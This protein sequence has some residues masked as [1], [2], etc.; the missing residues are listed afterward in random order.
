VKNGLIVDDFG[1]KFWYKDDMLHREDGPAM[2]RRRGI[3]YWYINGKLHREDGP[4]IEYP[5]GYGSW[6]YNG[7]LIL[8]NKEFKRLIK[9]KAFW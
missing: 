1:N 3:K 9:L 2:E 5:D 4:A 7:Q 6:F 8:N